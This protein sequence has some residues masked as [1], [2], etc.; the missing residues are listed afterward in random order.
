MYGSWRSD[1]RGKISA[2]C[3][4][5]F[6]A[7]WALAVTSSCRT[8]VRGYS[9]GGCR[10]SAMYP[11]KAGEGVFSRQRS[12]LRQ[13]HPGVRTYHPHRP[14]WLT[15]SVE[16]WDPGRVCW[17]QMAQLTPPRP[18]LWPHDA[19]S[20]SLE[21][22]LSAPSLWSRL[23]HRAWGAYCFFPSWLPGCSP[24]P[25]PPSWTG[26]RTRVAAAEKLPPEPPEE[27]ASVIQV[28]VTVP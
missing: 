26:R 8:Y 5:C 9:C 24:L 12:P 27:L 28:V 20:L 6:S 17:P 15:S 22:G 10:A 16:R 25:A 11:L 18:S 3:L 4:T 13:H 7:S 21:G 2:C 14:S 1:L 19:A 23:A